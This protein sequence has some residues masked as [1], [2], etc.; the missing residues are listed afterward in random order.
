MGSGMAVHSFASI[1]EIFAAPNEEERHA[2][3]EKVLQESKTFDTELRNAVTKKD[4]AERKKELLALE[5]LYEF[6]R[7][8]PTVEVSKLKRPALS[9]QEASQI[10]LTFQFQHFTP[11]LVAAGA[12]GE[13]IVEPLGV[14]V[15]EPG[16][17]YLNVRFT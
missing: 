2:V 5:S 6:K 11:I 7:S 4:A 10:N 14:D 15:V 1:G 17:S 8:H 16:M 13:A 12:A 9:S 3:R